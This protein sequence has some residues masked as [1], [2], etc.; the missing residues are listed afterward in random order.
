[1]SITLT[2]EGKIRLFPSGLS[3]TSCTITVKFKRLTDTNAA[4]NLISCY[5]DG[6][7]L[8]VMGFDSTG[9]NVVVSANYDATISSSLGTTTT[10]NWESMGLVLTGTNLIGYYQ[11]A[12][13]GSVSTQTIAQGTTFSIQQ[14]LIGS[15]Y[16]S[17][18]NGRIADVKI[19][20]T[21]LSAAEIAAE[22]NAQAPVKT[23]N[24]ISYSS[25]AGSDLNEASTANTSNV[26]YAN[27]WDPQPEANA[28]VNVDAP[29]YGAASIILTGADTLP[30]STGN[31]VITSNT[32]SSTWNISINEN[33]TT[34][35]TV[36]A[37]GT[38]AVTY[39][40]QTGQ[41]RAKFNINSS[42]GDVT[43]ASAPNYETPTDVDSNNIYEVTVVATDTALT[44][45]TQT[46]YVT[47]LNVLETLTITQV[48]SAQNG[49]PLT[50]QVNDEA[51]Q[52]VTG[53]VLSW[54]GTPA[55]S[56]GA[57][58]DIT[59]RAVV[60]TPSA[61][62]TYTLN[63]AKGAVTGNTSVTT[64][65]NHAPVITSNG[66]GSIATI[67]GSPGITYV[68]TVTATDSD[69]GNTILYSINGGADATKFTID[70]QT[71]ILRFV[72]APVATP[73]GDSNGDNLY[74]VNV[75]ASDG[76]ASAS[77]TIQV[78]LQE[79]TTV[80]SVKAYIH[81]KA[82]PESL[83]SGIVW[84]NGTGGALI[85]DKL[86]EFSSLNFSPALVNNQTEL[87]IPVPTSVSSLVAAGQTVKVYL[88]NTGKTTPIFPAQIYSA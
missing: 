67:T 60:T 75:Q 63:V 40:L 31:V 79:V 73:A 50:V 71:G 2:P 19:W 15:S 41:D 86:F 4:V 21:A 39:S 43:F 18:F 32:G 3:S 34:V 30:T 10:G 6:S 28:A 36:Q 11:T 59:G 81:R 74:I 5:D 62:G 58:T 29:T 69:V 20:D 47:V 85:G 9:D 54:A 35:A 88:Y 53:A 78:L 42:T 77:Q 68:T 1:M 51:N 37:S 22:F 65:L 52:L 44:T 14:L 72:S 24:L 26:A 17:G 27:L 76:L 23:A 12:I 45:A 83:I 8:H 70:S 66:G 48:T 7:H 38:G 49:G 84:L 57:T 13:G 87:V 56:A 64:S 33:T 82:L 46:L 61:V 80:S 16:Y 55:G 25:L